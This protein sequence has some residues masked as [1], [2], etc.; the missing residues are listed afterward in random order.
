[1][2]FVIERHNLL[3]SLTYIQSVVEKKN[4]I[5]ILAN[6][7]IK[8][9][10]GLLELTATDMDISIIDRIGAD[11][12]SEGSTTIPAQML[13]D[14]VRKLPDGSQIAISL[15]SNKIYLD[16]GSCH[17][18]LPTLPIDEFPS[19]DEGEMEIGFSMPASD[20]KRLVEKTKFAMSVDETRYY[21]NG[22]FLHVRDGK[23]LAAAT[24]GH[25]L[26]KIS[27]EAP[28]GAD[29][30]PDIIIPRKTVHELSKMLSR[31]DEVEIAISK[32]K[33][34]LSFGDTMLFSKLVDGNFPDYERVIP[35]N[36][37][38]KMGIDSNMLANAVDRVITIS[39]DKARA[40]KLLIANDNITLSA[41][42]GDIGVASEEI[43][44][45]SN[46]T[47]S[48]IAYN[49]RYLIEMLSQIPGK[50]EFVFQDNN[51]ATL[52]TDMNDLE[53][54]YVIMPIRV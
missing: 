24:D 35:I 40:V 17:F 10:R 30:M 4:I 1:M 39:S 9:E 54:L 46:A 38:K 16:T 51:S 37:D 3:K 5:P 18:T 2:K 33:I 14:I 32:N 34:R 15:E 50:A 8:A 27:L 31:D 19:L 6:V 49:A 23:L 48:E 11:I 36:N 41:S 26:A 25:R 53:S 21:L 44:A 20:L 42:G 13:Y 22:I 7:K 29:N 43:S 47:S 12:L 28:S 45:E 52:V